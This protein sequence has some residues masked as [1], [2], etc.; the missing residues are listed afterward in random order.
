[1]GVVVCAVIAFEEP[2]HRDDLEVS[3][4]YHLDTDYADEDYFYWHLSARGMNKMMIESDHMVVGY[5]PYSRLI[6]GRHTASFKFSASNYFRDISMEGCK[7]KCC[8]FYP[9]Y[10]QPNMLQPTSECLVEIS[11]RAIS[12]EEEVQPHLKRICRKQINTP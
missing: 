12:D 3:C 2:Y 4:V 9:L 8:G 5:I 10:I 11:G 1:M 7:V 6:N